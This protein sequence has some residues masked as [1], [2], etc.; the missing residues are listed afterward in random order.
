MIYKTWEGFLW[1]ERFC[2]YKKACISP[3]VN[4]TIGKEKLE[5]DTKSLRGLPG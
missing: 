3:R 5:V 4:M 2:G 1:Y